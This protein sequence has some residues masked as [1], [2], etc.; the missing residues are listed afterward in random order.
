MGEGTT[1]QSLKP[2][3]GSISIPVGNTGKTLDLT[4]REFTV[5]DEAWL[6]AQFPGEGELNRVF[7]E[8]SWPHIVRIAFHQCTVKSK[9]QI[10]R[11]KFKKDI[12]ENGKEIEVAKTGPEKLGKLIIDHEIRLLLLTELLKTRIGNLPVIEEIQGQVKVKKK[13]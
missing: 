2:V 12:D 6:Q 9:Q 8:Q 7:K 5:D 10:F 11:I 3:Q 13:A 1:L 4:F